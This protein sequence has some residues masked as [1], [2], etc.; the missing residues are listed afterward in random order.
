MKNIALSADDDLIDRAREVA[1]LQRR[2]L[3][4]AFREWL[5]QFTAESGNGQEVD[6]LMRRLRHVSA[7]RCFVRDEMNDAGLCATRSRLRQSTH[8]NV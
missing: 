1:R 7:G 5:Q 6:T 8:Q 3:N 2:T 4:A